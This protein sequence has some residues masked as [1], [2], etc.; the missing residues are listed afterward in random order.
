MEA[1][2]VCGVIYICSKLICLL[3]IFLLGLLAMIVRPEGKHNDWARLQ[4]G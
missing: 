3:R 4:L 2:E 1:S